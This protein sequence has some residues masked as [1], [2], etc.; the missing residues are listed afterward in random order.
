MYGVMDEIEIAKRAIHL[1]FPGLRMEAPLIRDVEEV[2]RGVFGK[3]PIMTG[4]VYRATDI[5]RAQRIAL[6]RVQKFSTKMS[7]EVEILYALR[8]EP[9]CVQM[10]DFF[11]SFEDRAM[12]MNIAFEY[13]PMT[14]EDMLDEFTQ[15][16]KKFTLKQIK[17]IM[18]ELL[19][20]MDEIHSKGIIHRDIKPDNIFIRED[21]SVIKFGDFGASKYENKSIPCYP[22][23][24]SKSYRAPELM[25]G[26]SV[27]T[28][29][30]DIWSLGCVFL[31]LF[32]LYPFFDRMKEDSQ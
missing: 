15:K 27:H 3:F 23:R 4:K 9:H 1:S 8:N 6:K 7:R 21:L 31:E 19:I 29:K 24:V 26:T 18:K 20:G 25:C 2:G 32:T 14:L 5:N 28:T 10:L 22:T 12:I 30:L 11:F 17:T 13:I 16:N